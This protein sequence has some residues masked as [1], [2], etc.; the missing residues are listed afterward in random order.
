MNEQP[1][2]T[3]PAASAFAAWLEGLRRKHAAA[4]SALAALRDH[5]GEY[6]LPA[7][8]ADVQALLAFREDMRL[9]D[10][11][12]SPDKL[13]QAA[14]AKVAAL[15]DAARQTAE[16]LVRWLLDGDDRLC[17]LAKG[18]A[19]PGVLATAGLEYPGVQFLTLQEEPYAPKERYAFLGG[20]TAPRPAWLDEAIPPEY[21]RP[22]GLIAV[23]ES[24]GT[25]PSWIGLSVVRA[26]AARC[27]AIVE[28][29]DRDERIQREH[30]ERE[31]RHRDYQDE[32]RRRQE[33]PAAYAREL[34]RRIERLEKER[35][36]Q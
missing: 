28:A 7:D 8:A 9:P 30:A 29:N 5:A 10:K 11:Q 2:N 14:L 24:A 26:A 34:E 12:C 17:Q 20:S 6:A 16:A 33:N 31:Q 13:M 21:R 23:C 36:G 19:L 27:R 15:A 32:L 35:A 18:G 22:H 1:D 25:L 4:A 3:R